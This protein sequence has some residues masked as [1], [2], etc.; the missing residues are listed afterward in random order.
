M[1]TTST[2]SVPS[3]VLFKD[4]T[5]EQQAT[6]NMWFAMG[7]PL[8]FKSWSTGD[9]QPKNLRGCPPKNLN[10]CYRIKPQDD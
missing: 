10:R 7:L 8:Q 2:D 5:E 1:P 3:D 4:M 9:W 6:V